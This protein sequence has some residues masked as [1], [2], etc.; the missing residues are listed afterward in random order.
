MYVCICMYDGFCGVTPCR[1][2]PKNTYDR[3]AVPVVGPNT[4]NIPTLDR[5]QNQYTPLPTARFRL[6]PSMCCTKPCR[7]RFQSLLSPA[8]RFHSSPLRAK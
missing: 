8:T 3:K 6:A 1:A 7:C 4:M 2:K 5:K